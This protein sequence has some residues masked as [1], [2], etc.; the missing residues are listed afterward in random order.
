[1][2]DDRDIWRAAELLVDRYGLGAGVEAEKRAD[3][4]LSRGDAEGAVT[5]RL[6]WEAISDLQTPEGTRH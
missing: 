1:M 2:I 5:W 3:E 4:L 6:I